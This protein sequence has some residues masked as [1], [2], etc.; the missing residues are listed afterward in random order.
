MTIPS[1]QPQYVSV[2]V[3]VLLSRLRSS[4]SPERA[5]APRKFCLF[6]FH[7]NAKFWC[8]FIHR[9]TK[10][11]AA[12][13]A[14][15]T[16]VDVEGIREDFIQL[17]QGVIDPCS[18]PPTC[19][20]DWWGFSGRWSM[21]W[22]VIGRRDGCGI[23]NPFIMC[24]DLSTLLVKPH[25]SDTPFIYDTQHSGLSLSRVAFAGGHTDGSVKPG[26][27][28]HNMPTVEWC[29]CHWPW[30]TLKGHFGDQKPEIQDVSP[31]K[32]TK[33]KGS[34]ASTTSVT[35]VFEFEGQFKVVRGHVHVSCQ[36][37]NSCWYLGTVRRDVVTTVWFWGRTML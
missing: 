22:F 29:H 25:P 6:F 1:D 20:Y 7:T 2:S 5:T 32:L 27:G 24:D 34:Q 13:R 26:Q 16:D 19:G 15:Y 11:N 37:I 17:W 18:P 12:V 28:T 4:Q 10:F 3:L 23:G 33:A 14:L 36:F 30:L 8:I 9:G 31:S 35:V 21:S